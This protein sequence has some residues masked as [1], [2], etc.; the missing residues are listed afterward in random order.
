MLAVLDL[1][2]L[3][4]VLGR[5]VE[6][7]FAQLQQCLVV[8]SGNAQ[9]ENMLGIH[10]IVERTGHHESFERRLIAFTVF[11]CHSEVLAILNHDGK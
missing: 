11:T 8:S 2:G 7:L 10:A 4:L 1:L 6:G 9:L 3:P 5:L